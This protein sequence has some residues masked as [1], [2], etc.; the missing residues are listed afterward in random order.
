MG[1]NL[2]LRCAMVHDGDIRR[3]DRAFSDAMRRGI[4]G[5]DMVWAG[6]E[7]RKARKACESEAETHTGTYANGC[8]P[9][10]R[11]DHFL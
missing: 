8:S 9:A 11:R 7:C 1:S 3:S 2:S 6:R 5:A 10:R 4:S